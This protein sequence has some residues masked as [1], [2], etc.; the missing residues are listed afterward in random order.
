MLVCPIGTAHLAMTVDIPVIG[1]TAITAAF[2][3]GITV[4]SVHRIVVFAMK[5]YVSVVV[6]NVH[7]V[8][9]SSAQ[10]VLVNVKNAKSYVAKNV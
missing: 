8:K 5:H 6:V 1:N 7:I 4:K 9:N 10:I 3:T 2:V